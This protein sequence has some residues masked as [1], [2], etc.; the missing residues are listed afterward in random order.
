MP[1][2]RFLG[3]LEDVGRRADLGVPELRRLGT[4]TRRGLP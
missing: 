1:S 4:E 2:L 3:N